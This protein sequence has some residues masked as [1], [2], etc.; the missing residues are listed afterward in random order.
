[1]VSRI[2]KDFAIKS[3]ISSAYINESIMAIGYF[4]IEI[5][6][7][8]YGVKKDDATALGNSYGAVIHRLELEGKHIAPTELIILPSLEL[9]QTTY[10][11]LYGRLDKQGS[12]EY[13]ISCE[14]LADTIYGNNLIWAPDGDEAF[15]D[16][17]FVFQ[18]DIDDKT[19][20]LIGYGT[21]DDYSVHTVRDLIISSDEYYST[22]KEWSDGF[23]MEWQSFE[24]T[25]L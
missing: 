22:L 9:A 12:W 21:N 11:S 5:K 3:F 15:D 16:G 4:L 6:G 1:M 17:S 7:V 8:T 25:V 10:N 20:R 19:V 24:K 13:D 18:F 2:N 23:Y 14:K